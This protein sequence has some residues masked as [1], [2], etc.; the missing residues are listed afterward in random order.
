MTPDTSTEQ[1]SKRLWRRYGANAIGMLEDI[2]RDPMQAEL[3][4]EN[5]EFIR[6]EIERAARH[7]MITKLEDFLRRR[8]KISLVVRH[9]DFIDSPGLR[10]ACEILFGDQAEVRLQEYIDSVARRQPA[11]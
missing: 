5:T 3:L 11:A 8:S 6:C 4:I 2:H 9:G 10:E 7:E 1:L